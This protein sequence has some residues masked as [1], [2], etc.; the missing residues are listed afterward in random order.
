MWYPS[1]ENPASG[2]F[3]YEQIKALMNI[4]VN[5]R[6]VHPIPF[7]PY[8][9]NRISIKYRKYTEMQKEEIAAGVHIYRPRYLTL[10]KHLVY[11]K[12]GKWMYEGVSD[13]IENVYE[14]WP[15]DIIHAHATYP[16]GFCANMIRDKISKNV[17]TL[18]TIHRFSI[19]DVPS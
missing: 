18:H 7:T 16:C 10:P 9:I 1:I 8:P 6:V 13:T 4:G 17:K 2:T 5:I 11:D 12:V 15:Y 19:I 14:N 3:V